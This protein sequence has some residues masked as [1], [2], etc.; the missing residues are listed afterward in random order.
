MVLGVEE[1]YCYQQVDKTIQTEGTIIFIGTDGI[2]E[3]HNGSGEMF[4][5]DRLHRLISDNADKSAEEIQDVVLQAVRKFRGN[6]AQE[7]DI[8]L[9][10]IKTV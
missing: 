2:W 5:K 7:D 8:T 4:G 9:V 6:A 10:V 3:A 1:D